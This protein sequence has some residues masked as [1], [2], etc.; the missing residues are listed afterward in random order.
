MK[1]SFAIFPNRL[2]YPVGENLQLTQFQEFLRLV[3]QYIAAYSLQVG[4]RSSQKPSPLEVL[5]DEMV[6]SYDNEEVNNACT[7]S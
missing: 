6:T 4:W 3:G 2:T 7:V 5:T 1:W